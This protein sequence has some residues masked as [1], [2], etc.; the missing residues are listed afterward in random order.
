MILFSS[1]MIGQ[2]IRLPGSKVVHFGV[3][4]QVDF[5]RQAR[6]ED[7]RAAK[8]PGS[9]DGR[10]RPREKAVGRRHCVEKAAVSTKKIQA[11]GKQN[12]SYIISPSDEGP[13]P[14]RSARKGWTAKTPKDELRL[15][16]AAAQHQ[17]HIENLQRSN[18]V[19]KHSRTTAEEESGAVLQQRR[20]GAVDVQALGTLDA[21]SPTHRKT[22]VCCCHFNLGQSIN[23]AAIG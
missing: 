2:K 17:K 19:E 7:R 5:F 1:A 21:L 18:N 16:I 12:G 13:R 14:R 4:Q 6:L 15:S 22:F 23:N 20:D 9:R 3:Q 11:S 8:L 10:S